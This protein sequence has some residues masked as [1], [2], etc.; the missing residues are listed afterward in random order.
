MKKPLVVGHIKIRKHI[1]F[2]FIY[3]MCI[4]YY[5]F[6][7]LFALLWD[8][9]VEKNCLDKKHICEVVFTLW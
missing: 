2:F 8:D 4:L 7:A 1:M 5:N 6:Y 3:F 9:L